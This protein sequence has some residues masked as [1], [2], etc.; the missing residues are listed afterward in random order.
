MGS[1]VL[2]LQK[3]ALSKDVS[4]ADLLRKAF[5]VSRK[6]K[7]TE[8]EIWI[9]RELDGYGEVPADQYPEYRKV[10]GVPKV[11]HPYHGWKEI[12]FESAEQAEALSTFPVRQSIA[13]IEHMLVG[14]NS[15][16]AFQA[17]Y[18]GELAAQL[19][20]AIKIQLQPSLHI[21]PSSLSNILDS[22]RNVV[23]HW[24]LK[25]E[26]DGVLG[27]DTSFTKQEIASAQQNHYTINNFNGNVSNTQIQ[28]GTINSSQKQNVSVDDLDKALADIVKTVQGSTATNEQK[29]IAEMCK[30]TIVSQANLPENIRDQSIIKKAWDKLSKLNTTISL[31]KAGYA[32]YTFAEPIVRSF[33]GF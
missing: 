18:P 30:D 16:G 31:G 7:V 13:E 27:E 17:P 33:F 2:D 29:E 22:V 12:N 10:H 9:K 23:L 19:M 1:L 32:A 21:Q 25:L 6:L 14:T 11:W 20:K 5:V 15:Q 3:E 28:Q 4:L 24:A 8:F 26:E